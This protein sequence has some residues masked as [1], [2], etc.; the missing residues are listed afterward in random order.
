ML[1]ET[2]RA[3]FDDERNFTD[4]GRGIADDVGITG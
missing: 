4:R 3:R 2:A 1:R